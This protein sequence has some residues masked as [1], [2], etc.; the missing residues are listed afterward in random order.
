MNEWP[1]DTEHCKS[2][3]YVIKTMERLERISLDLSRN[4][5][6]LVAV[7]GK[8]TALTERVVKLE[9]NQEDIKKFIYKVGGAIAFIA[10][11]SPILVTL[12]QK[13]L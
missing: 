6:E 1:C 13:L 10:I 2:H 5:S 7:V 12:L 11:T 4:Q 3:E 8:L 9:N